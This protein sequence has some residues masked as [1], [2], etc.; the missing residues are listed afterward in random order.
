QT[1]VTLQSTSQGDRLVAYGVY[2]AAALS[3]SALRDFLA[4]SLPDYMIPAVFVRLDTLP[5]TP[6]GKVDRRALPPPPENHPDLQPDY[7]RPQTEL[8]QAIAKIWQAVLQLE[9]V[10]IHDNFFEL[11]GHS[12]LLI[13]VNTQLRQ[14][15]QVDLSVLDLFRYPTIEA[16]ATHLSQRQTMP[17]HQPA[18]AASLNHQLAQRQQGKQRISQRR[19][20]RLK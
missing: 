18:V 11:G 19:Q 6:N 8:E 20:K 17:C 12:L 16:I 9:T 14:Q 1:V 10:G 15:L 13:Q 7:V 5:L 2:E 4:R 3:P